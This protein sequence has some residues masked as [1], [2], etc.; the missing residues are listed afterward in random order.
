[1][2]GRAKADMSK[3]NQGTA[4]AKGNSACMSF[5]GVDKVITDAVNP[6]H[7]PVD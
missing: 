7:N 1:M 4:P 3:A 6:D 5:K 2:S